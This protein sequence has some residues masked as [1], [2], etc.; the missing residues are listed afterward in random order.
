MRKCKNR[1]SGAQRHLATD[2]GNWTQ[3]PK[4]GRHWECGHLVSLY[5]GASTPVYYITP[6][7]ESDTSATSGGPPEL[8]IT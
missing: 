2:G 1:A 5:Q 6:L 4:Y 7:F 8:K 3:L